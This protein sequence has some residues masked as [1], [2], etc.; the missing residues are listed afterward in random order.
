MQTHYSRFTNIHYL[1]QYF[2]QVIYGVLVA[3]VEVVLVL[4]VPGYVVR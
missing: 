2:I 4:A 1:A 3:V